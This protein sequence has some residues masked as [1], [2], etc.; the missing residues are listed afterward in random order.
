MPISNFAA[1]PAEKMKKLYFSVK[2]LIKNIL[3]VIFDPYQC[4]LA[5]FRSNRPTGKIWDRHRFPWSIL[6]VQI[7]RILKI[8]VHLQ[9]RGQ[10]ISWS[11]YCKDFDCTSS[12]SGLKLNVD[13]Q[14]V[15][16]SPQ[17][18]IN[19]RM[20]PNQ[21]FDVIDWAGEKTVQGKEFTLQWAPDRKACASFIQISVKE[22]AGV[23]NGA[24]AQ[25]VRGDD[26]PSGVRSGKGSN[27]FNPSLNQ[28]HFCTPGAKFASKTGQVFLYCERHGKRYFDENLINWSENVSS[29]FEGVTRGSQV[30][31]VSE[32][33]H[34][35]PYK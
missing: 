2:N 12:Y 11:P 20:E 17:S 34:P 22:P 5:N 14:T 7:F 9:T 35:A 29:C 13:G 30:P 4:F 26:A 3:S 18:V 27:A 23:G 6:S 24:L 15:A 25:V 19:T 28:I 16:T 31:Q 33:R 10:R 21:S 1:G 32:I 8:C